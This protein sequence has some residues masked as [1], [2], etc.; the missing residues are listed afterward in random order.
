MSIL[1]PN[2]IDSKSHNRK[3]IELVCRC[4]DDGC[5]PIH[6]HAHPEYFYAAVCVPQPEPEFDW[7]QLDRARPL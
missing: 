4:S 1:T 2:L 5:C 6:C 7:D 3:T